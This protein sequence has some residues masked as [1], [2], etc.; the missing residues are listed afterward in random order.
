MR[1]EPA[2][3]RVRPLAPVLLAV[4]LL[5]VAC[6]PLTQST[7]IATTTTTRIGSTA[8]TDT[9]PV[10][11][12]G[13]SIGY[14]ISVYLRSRL[15]AATKRKLVSRVFGGT[16]ACDFLGMAKQDRLTL[17]PKYVVILFTGNTFTP[18]TG[19]VG[20]QPTVAER[21]NVTMKG[22]KDLM[23]QFPGSRIFLVGFVRN[24]NR[25]AD[26]DAGVVG[27]ID[28]LNFQLALLALATRNSYVS[29]AKVLYDK[30][31]RAQMQLP[32]SAALDGF[33]CGKSGV[34]TVRA[35][36]G[37]HL[38]PESPPAIQGV[39]P[40]CQVPSPG[41]NRVVSVVLR[42]ILRSIARS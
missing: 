25:Q 8:P 19:F 18:C 2:H 30:D 31:G 40:S 22:I 24:V 6:G 37:G 17:K 35:P 9:A 26:F 4:T 32:C 7:A 27:A 11:L 42:S 3:R 12:Y 1:T 28:I 23:A 29:T 10:V 41:A 13:D 14:E 16:N 33:W 34:V 38:C 15:F 36:D 5:S 21:V 20:K 39:L